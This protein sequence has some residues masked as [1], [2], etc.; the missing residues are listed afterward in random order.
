MYITLIETESIAMNC[1]DKSNKLSIH[2]FCLTFV[3]FRHISQVPVE[4]F[5]CP[6][7]S[8]CGFSNTIC[9]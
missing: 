4:K 5:A 8:F 1:F 3:T 7:Y 6:I 9:P 2:E